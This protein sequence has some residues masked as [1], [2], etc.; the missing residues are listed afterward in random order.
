MVGTVCTGCIVAMTKGSNNINGGVALVA[1]RARPAESLADR[2]SVPRQRR[3]IDRPVLF[4]VA[5]GQLPQLLQQRAR[6][7]RP[8]T[9]RLK[10]GRSI[11]DSGSG[12]LSG[13]TPSYGDAARV[14]VDAGDLRDALCRAPHSV[15]ESVR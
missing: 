14:N 4:W 8:R 1:F 6:G 13:M 10:V 12:T 3:P 11:G 9:I 15:D 2:S 5:D 7:A